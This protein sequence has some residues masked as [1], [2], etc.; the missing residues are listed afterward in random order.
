MLRPLEKADLEK[1]LK[2]RNATNVRQSFYSQHEISW[3]EHQLWF[4]KM[5]AD[6]TKCWYLYLS[7]GDKPNGVV[8][9]TEWV[10]AQGTAF[11]G[12]YA[13]PNATS[14]TGMRMSLAALNHAFSKLTIQKLNADVLASNPKSLTMHKNVGFIEEGCFRKQYFN[15]KERIDVIRLGMLASEWAKNRQML[16]TIISRLDKN[17]N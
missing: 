17:A 8:Y 16:K 13:N 5:Q 7:K 14:G 3:D 2:W 4:Q 10:R 12:F 15:G 6:D 9:F 11:W 1:I